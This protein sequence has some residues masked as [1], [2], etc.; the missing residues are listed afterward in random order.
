MKGYGLPRFAWLDFPDQADI[1]AFALKGSIGYLKKSGGDYPSAMR[2]S[3][4]RRTRRIYKRL[5][6]NESKNNILM[7]ISMNNEEKWI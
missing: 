2:S 4:K 5:A 1:K 3:Q 7:E 6:R